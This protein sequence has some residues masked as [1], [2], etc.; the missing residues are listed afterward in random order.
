ML[1]VFF[2]LV[3]VG[4]AIW[5]GGTRFVIFVVLPIFLMQ[6][7]LFFFEEHEIT[8]SNFIFRS[9]NRYIIA[10]E[11]IKELTGYEMKDINRDNCYSAINNMLKNLETQENILKIVAKIRFE[12]CIEKQGYIEPILKIAKKYNLIDGV[13]FYNPKISFKEAVQMMLSNEIILLIVFLMGHSLYAYFFKNDEIFLNIFI[14]I[15]CCIFL[16]GPILILISDK[17]HENKIKV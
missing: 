4:I 2:C 17:I 15:L 3:I 10:Y 16:I 5:F 11:K 9:K 6:I 1:I 14:G 13:E 12:T 8:L 7:L